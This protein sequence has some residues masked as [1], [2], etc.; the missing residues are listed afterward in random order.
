MTMTATLLIISGNNPERKIL[1]NPAP[2]DIERA[3][4]VHV[5][6]FTSKGDLLLA[7]SEGIFSVQEWNE[8][9]SEAERVC[10]GSMSSEDADAMRDEGEDDV[11]SGMVG[12]IKS[13]L[14]DKVETDLQWRT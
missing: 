3:S 2:V 12:F 1:R 11:Q 7:E 9:Y 13:T 4:S 5:L 8:V 14:R 6:A 10:L